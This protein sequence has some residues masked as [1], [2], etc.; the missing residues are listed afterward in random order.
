MI[1]F[2]R[3]REQRPL[4]RRE[5]TDLARRDADESGERRAAESKLIWAGER[6]LRRSYQPPPAA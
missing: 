2:V 4:T 3:Y 1:D 5:S 6:F